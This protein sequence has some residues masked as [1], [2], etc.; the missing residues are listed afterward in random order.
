MDLATL[1]AE[2]VTRGLTPTLADGK[3]AI[4]GPVD[5]LTAPLKAGLAEHRETLR[6]MLTPTPA[7]LPP[8]NADG[9]PDLAFADTAEADDGLR[10]VGAY[11]EQLAA[12]VMAN[13]PKH[14]ANL[15]TDLRGDPCRRCGFTPAVLTLIHEG[16]TV[17][18]DCATCGAFCEFSAWHD[19]EAAA[20]AF[21]LPKLPTP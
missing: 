12:D 4:G 2:L 10:T 9:L 7:E 20:E 5:R 16:G 3:L 8:E 6:A 1:T 21:A 19:A 17:R 14:A 13:N 18:R 15:T 11:F